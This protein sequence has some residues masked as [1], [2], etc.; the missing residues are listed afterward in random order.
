MTSHQRPHRGRAWLLGV[1]VPLLITA[2]AWGVIIALLP[3]LPDP[4]AL[5]WGFSGVDRTGST[6]ELVT[7]MA[8]IS[9]ISLVVMA[10]FVILTGRQALTR[11]MTLGVAVALATLFAGVSLTTVLV[12]VDAPSALDAGSPDLG[13]TISLVVAVALGAVAG[14]LAGADPSRPAA[15][16]LAEDAD[17][18]DL[19][20]GQRA[21]WVQS[22][23][24]LGP[25]A[26]WMLVLVVGVLAVGLWLL[27]DTL[28]PLVVLL[29]IAALVLT[30]TSW[31]VQV[32]SR[33][34]TARGAFGWP[35]QHVPADEVER[36]DV[37]TVRP[38]AEFGGWGLRT[39]VS[40]TVG[41][42]IRSGEAIAV[43]RS[44]GRRFVVTVDGAATGAAL[45]NTYALRAR[46]EPAR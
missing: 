13:I 38:F 33:G 5:H 44:G 30:M 27:T 41:V 26:T 17:T 25:T 3:R 12:Q 36:A 37:V 32:D 43:E 22:V 20:D 6:G 1:L 24:G 40:G 2:A 18:A 45:L 42:V 28:F 46:T 9:G 15:G 31:R 11:R 19:P 10:A 4:A 21:V 7:S 16:P 35:R 8:V 29:P 23:A 39:A 34:L 14:A